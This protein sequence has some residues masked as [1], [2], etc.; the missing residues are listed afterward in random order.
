MSLDTRTNISSSNYLSFPCGT[1]TRHDTVRVMARVVAKYHDDALGAVS[2]HMTLGSS[3]RPSVVEFMLLPEAA[4]H[5][6][7]RPHVTP[8]GHVVG[9]S[10]ILCPHRDTPKLDH[11]KSLYQ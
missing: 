11:L 5:W 9:V 1:A 4:T 7:I 10:K 8:T 3:C 6:S 2:Q